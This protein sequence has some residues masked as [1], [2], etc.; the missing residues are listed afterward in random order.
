MKSALKQLGYIAFLGLYSMALGTLV[1]DMPVS[2]AGWEHLLLAL[3]MVGA[4]ALCMLEM[5]KRL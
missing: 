1:G 3:P 2:Q 4:T 5:S